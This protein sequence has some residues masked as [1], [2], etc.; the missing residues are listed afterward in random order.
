MP[1]NTRSSS[2]SHLKNQED[3]VLRKIREMSPTKKAK[4][5]RVINKYNKTR[6]K[7]KEQRQ[8]SE[9][10]LKKMKRLYGKRAAT[11]TDFTYRKNLPG[12]LTANILGMARDMEKLEKQVK[13][14]LEKSNKE[15]DKL[16]KLLEKLRTKIINSDDLIFLY[17]SPNEQRSRLSPEV[18]EQLTDD[19]LAYEL[20]EEQILNRNYLSKENKA[21][22]ELETLNAKISV[23]ANQIQSLA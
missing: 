21:I 12:H 19:R 13:Q 16:E 3:S 7:L 9:K 22:N 15:K 10:T 6:K 14:K 8:K 23:L 2:R 20:Q 1:R 4:L 11:Y 18:L 17:S 5:N